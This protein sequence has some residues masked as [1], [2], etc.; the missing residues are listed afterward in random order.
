MSVSQT[1]TLTEVSGSVNNTNNTSQVRILWQSTQAG[2]SWNGYTR[3][4]KYYVSINGGAETEYSVSYT[5]PQSTTTTIVDTTITVAHKPDGKGT[6]KVRTW[7]DT[8]I[9]AGVVELSKTLTLTTIPRGS[10]I[11]FVA[12]HSVGKFQI[13]WTPHSTSFKY[14]LRFIVG[15]WSY[16][17]EII[18][19]KKTSEYVYLTDI[20][21][22]DYANYITSGKDG[23]IQIL[24]YTIFPDDWGLSESVDR[25][26]F[27]ITVPYNDK[28][29]PSVT[30][31]LSP[32]SSL[33]EKFN[34]L[35]IQN[36]T[37]VMA[38]FTGSEAKYSATI[39]SCSIS[40][41]GK[42]YES[43]CRSEVLSQYGT[44][45]V[46]GTVTD[47]R[48]YSASKTQN[49]TVIPY[50]KPSIIP[51]N[52]ESSIVCKRSDSN[53][54]L[55]ASGTC[56]RVK[57]GKDFAK[58]VVDDVQKNFCVLR[59]KYKAEEGDSWGDWIDIISKESQ[60]Y[61][62]DTTLTDINLSKSKTYL[63]QIE[64]IDDIG[65]SS[66][67]LITI[68]TADCIYHL[69][70]GGKAIGVGKYAEKDY[71][72]DVDDKWEVNVR[73]E[74]RAGHIAAI[75]S[76]SGKDFNELNSATG[77]YYDSASPLS[78]GCSNYPVN[79][80]GRSEIGM[81]EVI[82]AGDFAYQTYRTWDGYVF[83][84][85][86]YREGGWTAWKQLTLTDI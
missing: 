72:V 8:S 12:Y 75:G 10:T 30:M 74:F 31:T 28:T 14:Y 27:T 56:L 33:P 44:I 71:I 70:K 60:L 6:V 85:S 23:T 76:Y 9:S 35:Y 22:L 58:V 18:Q 41:E 68:P 7:M 43:S 79:E 65:E 25:R 32:I 3:T 62:V 39:S 61:A 73:G 69:K 34:G 20:L 80:M 37:G 2:D 59:L 84:R 42:T 86:Y 64:A 81:L 15:M 50:F 66:T 83:M 55:T 29:K 21:P 38:D 78:A 77:Y 45:P 57:A 26:Y 16:D 17:T 49:I 24:L 11:S 67:M 82:C 46:I 53:G 13:N 54:N 47:S 52:G 36:K 19:P 40:V 5:L 51:Y 63:V 48:G 1:L 4:A